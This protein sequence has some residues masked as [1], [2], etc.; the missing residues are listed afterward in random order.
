[1]QVIEE[2][3]PG[4]IMSEH[5]L[6][7]GPLRPVGKGRILRFQ[8]RF[9]E[10]SDH[11]KEGQLVD[12]AG[13]A[14]AFG[15]FH[16]RLQSGSHADAKLLRVR[17]TLRLNKCQPQDDCKRVLITG[18]KAVGAQDMLLHRNLRTVRRTSTLSR[19]SARDPGK[20]G[21][22]GYGSGNYLREYLIGQKPDHE[23]FAPRKA[24]R[25]S[26]NRKRILYSYLQARASSQLTATRPHT[27]DGETLRCVRRK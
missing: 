1:M 17:M 13:I 15:L 24:D 22:G 16:C 2:H 6:L 26:P 11:G 10:K 12:F 3:L 4:A 18:C 7:Q 25:Q 21:N 9:I 14:G 19:F 5:F 20:T 23:I 27:R 8:Y